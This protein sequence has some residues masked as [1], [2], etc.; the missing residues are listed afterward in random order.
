MQIPSR[1]AAAVLLALAACAA[2]PAAPAPPPA[3]GSRLDH[4][5]QAAIMA[6]HH[7]TRRPDRL[8]GDPAEAAL[9]VARLEYITTALREPQYGAI[10][11]VTVPR[12]EQARAA[13]RAALGIPAT[14]PGAI[15]SAAFAET[16]RRLA[17]DDR[18]S[19]AEALAPVAGGRPPAAMLAGLDHLVP[20]PIVADAVASAEHAWHVRLSPTEE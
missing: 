15:V 2:E 10:E 20:P 11:P 7:S 13:L 5:L 14:L 1:G 8:A 9:V 19:A 4:P 16:A 12:L 17:A 6:L 18:T 3:N